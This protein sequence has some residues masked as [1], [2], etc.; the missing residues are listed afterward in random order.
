MRKITRLLAIAVALLWTGTAFAAINPT[1]AWWNAETFEGIAAG[2]DQK[3]G[4]TNNGGSPYVMTQTL[5]AQTNGSA[6]G[7]VLGFPMASSTAFGESSAQSGGR[8]VYKTFTN[9]LSG[10]VYVKTS[11]YQSTSGTTYSLKNTAGTTVFE[12]GGNGWSSGTTL[13]TTAT[14][15]TL[16]AMGTR[17]KWADIE[18]VLDIANTKLDTLNITFAGTTKSYTKTNLAA[19]TDIKSLYVS[20]TRSYCGAGLDNTTFGQLASNNIKTLTGT[21]S[22]QT[23]STSA[24]TADFNVLTFTNAMGKDYIIPKTDLDIVWSI[25]DYGT[26]SS[27]DQALVTLTRSAS[28]NRIATLS[29]G[30]ITADATITLSAVHGATTITKQVMVK[31]LSVAGLKSGLAE[32]ISTANLLMTSASDSNPYITGIKSTLN[33]YVNAAQ[34]VIDNASATI[35]EATSALSNIEAGNSTFTA[36]IAPYNDF[37]TY[38]GTV[39]TAHNAE[40]RTANFFVTVKGTLAS[41]ISGATAARD[42]ISVVSGITSTKSTLEA[43][44]AQ[45]NL[46]VPAYSSLETGIS[47]V[48]ARLA[49]VT[50]RSGIRFLMFT[51]A[52]VTDLNSAKTTADG[53]LS[54]AT[55]VLELTSA[56]TNLETALTTFNAVP[57]VAPS[58]TNYYRIYT[59]GSDGG[60]GGSNKSILLA[61]T[62]RTTS[63]VSLN[64]TPMQ[65]ATSL[66][67]GDSA[68]W[69]ITV[70]TTNSSYIIQNKATGQYLSGTGF[71]ATSAE[72][73]LPEAKSQL[74]NIQ[75]PGDPNFLY[76]I[77]NSSTKALEV[78]LWTSP[79]GV[80][81]NNSGYADRYRFAYQFEELQTPAISTVESSVN[82][83]TTTVG[84]PAN[85]TLS[86]SGTNLY[87]TMTLGITGTNAGLFSVSPATYE[88]TNSFITN[89]TVTITYTPTALTTTNDVAD[90]SIGIAGGNTLIYNLEGQATV[91]TD[92]TSPENNIKV[93]SVQNR[94]IVTGVNSYVVYNLQG[95]KIADVKNNNANTSMIL[96]KGIYFVRSTENVQKVIIK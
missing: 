62:N 77:V 21:S 78:D 25:S 50:P 63:V 19:G 23:N 38:I 93:Y 86:L 30:S 32:E 36:A 39:Q 89:S 54:S 14:A 74:F 85:I 4:W 33:G 94:L 96:N 76:A 31:N 29:A 26:L 81:V 73:T 45:F 60:D 42:T 22:L 90:L 43:A 35:E 83:F 53:I 67:L 52:A 49:A 75:Y 15:N 20:M 79:F 91:A 13:W 46:D 11:F 69:S 61:H 72:F 40:V 51:T 84:T 10:Y 56:K 82:T 18:F 8:G 47:T 65:N 7:V 71:S 9:A 27:G 66:A 1:T 28:D 58:S 3:T 6:T 2:T 24:V 12:F 41:A 92:L 37:T 55:T 5:A 34:V 64:Y 57:R 16:V 88:T 48:V 95:I 70:G 87:G 59:Y 44:L 68:L 17:A 80:F